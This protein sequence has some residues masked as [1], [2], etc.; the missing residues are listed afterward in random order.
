MLRTAEDCRSKATECE[1]RVGSATYFEMKV[2][3]IENLP[4]SGAA[5][6]TGLNSLLPFP[7]AQVDRRGRW[8]ALY[9]V[10]LMGR[11]VSRRPEFSDQSLKP[12][13]GLSDHGGSGS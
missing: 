3:N 4:W 9:V 6:P 2:S 1:K 8:A 5:W 12:T 13:G 11:Y 10:L 7:N